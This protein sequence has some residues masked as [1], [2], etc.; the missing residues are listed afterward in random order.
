MRISI[1]EPLERAYAH[2]FLVHFVVPIM[3]REGL[4]TNAAWGRFLPLLRNN[5]G[6][7]LIYGL[8]ILLLWFGVGFALLLVVVFTCCIAAIPLV[9]PY[10]STVTLLPVYV[11]FRA[12]GVEFLGQLLPSVGLPAPAAVGDE[13]G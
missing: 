12:F 6:S 13:T 10:I 4:A 2:M 8:F 3:H 7:F 5:L 9:I 11:V 1:I